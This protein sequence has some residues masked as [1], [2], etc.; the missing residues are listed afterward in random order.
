MKHER[1]DDVANLV[2]D[3]RGRRVDR[4]LWVARRRWMCRALMHYKADEKKFNSPRFKKLAPANGPPV[5][6]DSI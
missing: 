5:F 3:K 2:R 4:L 6:R 1:V